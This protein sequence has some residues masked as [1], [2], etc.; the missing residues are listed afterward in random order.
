MNLLVASVW[1]LVSDGVRINFEGRTGGGVGSLVRSLE[2]GSQNQ[3]SCL[4]TIE[5][6]EE[7]EE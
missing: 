7:Q 3:V 5:K 1:C 2:V 4:G 6:K